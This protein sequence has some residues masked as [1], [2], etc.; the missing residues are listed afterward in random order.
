MKLVEQTFGWPPVIL[1]AC[2]SVVM[3]GSF[4]MGTQGEYLLQ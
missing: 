2:V 3:S 4:Q 1:I